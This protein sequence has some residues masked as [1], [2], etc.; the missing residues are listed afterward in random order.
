MI[1]YHPE[2]R[3][4][5]AMVTYHR[6]KAYFE[7]RSGIAFCPAVDGAAEVEPEAGTIYAALPPT[8]NI[9]PRQKNNEKQQKKTCHHFTL[10]QREMV[11][12]VIILP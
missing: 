11:L 8:V 9:L 7:K 5:G 6:N 10:N 4:A 12:N 3:R 1:L 2:V